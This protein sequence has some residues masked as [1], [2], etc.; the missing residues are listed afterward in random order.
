M[1]TF[2]N[3]NTFVLTEP[4]INYTSHGY[5][6][7]LSEVSPLCSIYRPD[8]SCGWGSVCDVLFNISFNYCLDAVPK[9]A[10]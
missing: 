8:Y 6:R 9:Q 7:K 2:S 1:Y 10:Y 4:Y 5:H 3:E